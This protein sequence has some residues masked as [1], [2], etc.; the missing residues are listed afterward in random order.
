MDRYTGVPSFNLP[1]VHMGALFTQFPFSDPFSSTH[2][3]PINFGIGDQLML[4]PVHVNP[5]V[6]G[7]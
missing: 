1:I 5:I 2:H 4:W 7:R 3:G 6:F